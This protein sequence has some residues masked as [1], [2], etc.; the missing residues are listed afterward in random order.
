MLHVS[1][2]DADHVR[3]YSITRGNTGGWEVRRE[4]DRVVRS[5]AV[6]HDWHRVER[7]RALIEM[8]VHAL[9]AAGWTVV[10]SQV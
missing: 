3:R 2:R 5:S 1:L 10:R 8:E 4:E 6:Y 7:A 9:T